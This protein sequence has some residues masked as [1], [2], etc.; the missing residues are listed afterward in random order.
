MP[1]DPINPQVIT[2]PL[3]SLLQIQNKVSDTP[4]QALVETV[5]VVPQRAVR[6]EYLPF[7]LIKLN[8]KPGPNRALAFKKNRHRCIRST[9]KMNRQD[10]KKRK[11]GKKEQ[12]SYEAFFRRFWVHSL[13]SLFLILASLASWRFISLGILDF[14]VYET[15][16]TKS[17]R[18]CRRAPGSCPLFR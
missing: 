11:R 6:A 5:L 10:A 13:F 4:A 17:C 8:V 2:S 9:I 14:T 7:V 18:F 16:S 3:N 1:P 12:K 15:A